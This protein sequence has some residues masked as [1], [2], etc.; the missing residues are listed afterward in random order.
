M[1]V[2]VLFESALLPNM[3][4]VSFVLRLTR[5][6]LNYRNANSAMLSEEEQFTIFA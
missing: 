4:S 5:S 3:L 1:A 2:I 6:K